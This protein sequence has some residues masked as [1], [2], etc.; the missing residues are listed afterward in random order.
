M[1]WETLEVDPDYEICT[2]YP[3]QIRRKS[4]GYVIAERENQKSQYIQIKL[5]G[6]L[7]YKH[8]VIATQW[9]KNDDP[10]NKVEVDHRNRIKTDNHAE[11]LC[12][13]TR[14]MN[15]LNRTGWGQYKFE[16]VDDLPV[17]AVP[18]IVYK[19]WEFEGYFMDQNSDV[20][21][22]NGEQ[23]RKMRVN[24]ENKVRLWDINHK[25]HNIGIRGLRREFI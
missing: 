11:N 14:R 8:V 13:K 22:D 16:Y 20:W 5:N 24:A 4:N 3:Y 9:V 21:F 17:D 6:R 15:D 23:Y 7:Y 25:L 10:E 12:W 19:N 18:I 2:E 1:N